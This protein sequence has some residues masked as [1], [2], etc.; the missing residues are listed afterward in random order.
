MAWLVA[1]ASGVDVDSEVVGLAAGAAGLYTL[2]DRM[3]STHIFVAQSHGTVW[4]SLVRFMTRGKRAT[5][6]SRVPG[7][8][9]GVAGWACWK[10]G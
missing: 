1:F 4:V 3:T 10:E 2:P 9:V 8:L 5:S 6:S 7:K